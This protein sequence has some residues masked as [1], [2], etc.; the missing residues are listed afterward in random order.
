MTP[1]RSGCAKT[2]TLGRLHASSTL[3]CRLRPHSQEIYAYQQRV[4]SINFSAITTRL[5]V[6]RACSR[7]A[8]FMPS[9]AH[10]AAADRYLAGTK[11]LAIEYSGG[12]V[13]LQD[14][15]VFIA[16]SDAAYADDHN[17]RKSSDGF[18]FQLYGGLIDWHAGK[19]KTVTLSSTE[20][21]LLALSFASREAI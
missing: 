17:T 10:Q 8:E 13:K 20:A 16:S 15:H 1:E 14:Q 6:S 9:P 12:D 3:P 18:L 7:L 4:G 21:E 5:D 11:H 19:Q 2:P